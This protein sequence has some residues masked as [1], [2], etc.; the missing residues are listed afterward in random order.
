MANSTVTAGTLSP[1][2]ISTLSWL[3]W[4]EISILVVAL[5]LLAAVYTQPKFLMRLLR[6]RYPDAI[7]FAETDTP[8]V[9]LTIDDA[10]SN[11]TPL[12]LDV[13][14]KNGVKATF[15]IIQ[16]NVVGREDIVQ[17]IVDEGHVIGNHFVVD[18]ASIRDE[19]DVFERK[20]LQC[21]ETLLKYQKR[22]RW[23]R[24]GS[25]WFNKSM[26]AVAK[27]HGY[28]F[29]L[30]SV[31]PHDAQVR[32]SK[33]NA[34]HIKTL[35]RCGSVLIV[36]DR[37]WSVAVLDEALPVLTKKFTF[38]PLE[39]MERVYESP[40]AFPDAQV[41]TT[42]DEST[43]LLP[44]TD[45][46][47]I[48]RIETLG[49]AISAIFTLLSVLLSG[50]E[51]WTH[52]TCNPVAS[53]RKYIVRILLMVPIYAVTSYL[54]L[55]F[56]QH[57][58]IFETIR[59]CYEAFALHSFYY[60][61]VVYLG[62]H[63]V[64]ANT[65]RSKKQV[66]HLFGVQ[67]CIPTW[68][69]GNKFVRLTAF[70]ILQY[71]PVKLT[72]SFL[73][74]VS[75]LL[76]VYGEGEMLNPLRAYGYLCFIL[77]LSQSWALYCLTL[78]YQATVDEL[79]P[80]RPLPKFLAIKMIIF[81]TFWQSMSITLLQIVGIINDDWDIGCTPSWT[82]N[83]IASALNDFIICCE[84]L[85]FAI[86][87]HY[88][89]GIEAHL[90][91]Q[92]HQ[93]EDTT[94]KAPL[95]AHF[96]DVINVNDVRKDIKNSRQEIL[97]KK[98]QLAAPVAV[99]LSPF[100]AGATIILGSWDLY[101]VSA[102]PMETQTRKFTRR[103]IFCTPFTAFLT[104]LS[105]IFPGQ[106]IWFD[107]LINLYLWAAWHALYSI[108]MEHLGGMAVLAR[109]LRNKQHHVN[110]V[111]GLQWCLHPWT[112]GP[113]FVRFCSLGNLQFVP[114]KLLVTLL[115]LIAYWSGILGNEELFNLAR[116]FPW[117][118]LILSLSQ[119]YAFYCVIFFYNGVSNELSAIHPLRKII[120]TSLLVFGMYWQQIA[121]NSFIFYNDFTSNWHVQCQ[122]ND[123]L[124]KTEIGEFLPHLLTNYELLLFAIAQHFIFPIEEL[125][126][127]SSERKPI[128]MQDS[129]LYSEG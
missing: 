123:C 129:N 54:A 41:P 21:H 87:H 27:K 95:L 93:Q 15:F 38:I 12:I 40:E 122:E 35:T 86:I 70:G 110:H 102:V 36:H 53:I 66:K 18:E 74:L 51:I 103:L 19:I 58:L 107:F 105:L 100:V 45:L 62:G 118:T 20:L 71:I 81:F 64:L 63:S 75:S 31:Y 104:Y 30:G 32:F 17:R 96:M 78:F 46:E 7:W 73:T 55:V 23:A 60:F 65:L 26:V 89:F 115:T 116:A 120:F 33:I 16:S 101:R 80:I 25:G 88:A 50:W 2:L 117:L 3:Q 98:Q 94:V 44:Q 126:I 48:M 85:I 106:W 67:Y 34:I 43:A 108:L 113:A 47:K 84:M 72:C 79:T 13:L 90:R 8:V 121:I 9:S 22:V 68:P 109:K 4:L 91:M 42:A 61:L 14:K 97:T 112:V 125:L 28:R 56:N 11:N 57:K 99:E 114:V 82:A 69:M 6:K 39:E 128:V 10:P 1:S 5:L 24:P 37:P 111:L 52:L 83:A 59:D 49:Y 119:L 76:G 127:S 124:N 92:D 77:T 29:A